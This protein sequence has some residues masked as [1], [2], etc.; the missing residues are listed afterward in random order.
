MKKYTVLLVV[1]HKYRDLQSLTLIGF[2]LTNKNIQVSYVAYGKHEPVIK[3]NNPDLIFFPKPVGVPLYKLI[4][5]KAQGKQIGVI[6]TEGNP[7][8]KEFKFKIKVSPDVYFY[9]NEKM[10]N[11][12]NLEE[13]GC[14]KKVLGCPRLDLSHKS[15]SWM[16]PNSKESLKSLHLNP[17]YTTITIGTILD[18]AFSDHE[19]LLKRE[20]NHKTFLESDIDYVKFVKSSNR[21]LEIVLELIPK[22]FKKYKEINIVLKPHPNEDVS[23][24][25]DYEQKLNNENFKVMVGEEINALLNISHCHIAFEAC[26][27]IFES[28]LKNV[29]VI[30]LNTKYSSE[31]FGEEHIA[32]SDHVAYSSKDCITF[33]DEILQNKPRFDKKSFNV[34]LEKYYHKHDGRR[35]QSYADEIHK[36]LINQSLGKIGLFNYLLKNPGHLQFLVSALIRLPLSKLKRFI[37]GTFLSKKDVHTKKGLDSRGR[38]D[39]RIKK[40]DELYWLKIYKKNEKRLLSQ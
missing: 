26:T 37:I 20:K 6:D 21:Q 35:C 31:M 9:W 4:K 29:P 1:D 40:G 22:I 18:Y 12:D 14:F 24:W 23:Y 30:E 11:K 8:D 33:I 16:L 36:Y 25:L 13:K 38:Y 19:E 3:N 7:Q 5:W 34:Y 39:N 28:M 27:T 32:L 17:N 15:F 2:F 10:Y